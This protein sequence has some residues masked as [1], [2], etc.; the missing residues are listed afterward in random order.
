MVTLLSAW[1]GVV[2]VAQ[3]P[4]L[5]PQVNPSL[6]RVFVH[7]ADAGH[8]EELAARRQSSADLAQAIAGQ[9]KG[10]V[11]TVVETEAGAD[12]TV[13]VIERQI[14]VPRVVF[15]LGPPRTGGGQGAMAPP[16]RHAT[17]VVTLELTSGS[18]PVEI[19]NKNRVVE[20]ASGWT[21]AAGDIAKQIEQWVA[22]R[23]A[24]ILKAR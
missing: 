3:S 12:V 24:A 22:G 19:K 9:K 11:L 2:L 16:T 6:I 13:E 18:D 20:S 15:G 5:A 21:S 17:L 1:F 7:T 4:A 8:P 23:R 10:T 14:S